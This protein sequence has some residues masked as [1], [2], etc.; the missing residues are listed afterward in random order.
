MTF[1]CSTSNTIT[2]NAIIIQMLNEFIGEKI[3]NKEKEIK[4][5]KMIKDFSILEYLMFLP[6]EAWNR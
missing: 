2:N 1:T 6:I 5:K 4:H 3:T